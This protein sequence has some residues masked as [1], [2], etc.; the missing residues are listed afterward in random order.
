MQADSH[1]NDGFVGPNGPCVSSLDL[2]CRRHRL[3]GAGEGEEERIALRVD[4]DSTRRAKG[5]ADDAAVSS[6]HL[7]VS[8]PELLQQRGRRFHVREHAR[9]RPGRQRHE[10]HRRAVGARDDLSSPVAGGH[11]STAVR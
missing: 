11:R 9:D 8:I 2:D 6:E 3:T 5:V 7:P 1:T 4:L 10:C